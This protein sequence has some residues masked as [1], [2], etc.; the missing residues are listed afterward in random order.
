M[1]WTNFYKDEKVSVIRELQ[2]KELKKDL[3][4]NSVCS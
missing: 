3:L 1:Y 4:E 2:W